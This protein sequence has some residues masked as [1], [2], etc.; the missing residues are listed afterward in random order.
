MKGKPF[1]TVLAAGFGMVV[2]ATV[3]A[4]PAQAD[5]TS[6]TDYRTLAGVGSDTTQDVL[7]GLGTSITNG[8]GNPIIAS[9]DARGTAAITTKAPAAN[10]DCTFTRPNGSGAGRTVLRASQEGGAVP[11]MINADVRDCVDFARSSSPPSTLGTTG[12]YSYVSFGVDGVT[13]ALNANSDLPTSLT[14]VQLQRIFRCQLTSIAGVPVQPRLIQ[15]GSGTRAFWNTK[16]VITDGD[17]AFGDYPCLTVLPAVQEHDG[18]AINGHV[19]QIIPMSIGQ[20]ISQENAG[21]TIGGV[22]VD[23][24]DRRGESRLGKV[25]NVGPRTGAGGFVG[26]L[27]INFPYVRDVYNVVPTVDLTDPTI[28]GVFV[29]AGSAVCSRQTIIEA[30]GFGYRPSTGSQPADLLK[31]GCGD[32]YLRA[33]S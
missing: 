10:P 25:N 17:I 29:G 16:M 1:G 23:V 27:N 11:G 2:L 4:A 18:T 13:Y 8:S 19:D 5:P 6:P 15:A 22:L 33:N 3:M 21:Q 7:N 12:N 26:P 30:F 31:Q 20:Y 9:W 32:T 28:G 14:I 24:V